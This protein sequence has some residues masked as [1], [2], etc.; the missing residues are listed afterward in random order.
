MLLSAVG[1]RQSA[2]ELFCGF[3]V[4]VWP[5][6]RRE[7]LGLRT[8]VSELKKGLAPGTEKS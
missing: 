4:A 5:R 6:L 3:V 2:G 8:L 7:V 1:G